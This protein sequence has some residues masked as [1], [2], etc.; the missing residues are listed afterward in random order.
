MTAILA[1]CYPE[2]FVG[3]C[4]HCGVPAGAAQ[5]L[6]SA[7]NVMRHGAPVQGS[8]QGT[9]IPLI[10]FQGC[11]DDLVHPRNATALVRSACTA[12]GITAARDVQ[13]GRV[14]YAAV[15]SA[16]LVEHCE[17]TGAGHAWSGGHVSGSCT[18]PGGLIASAE[19]LRFALSH[20]SEQARH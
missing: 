19:M 8:S 5:D 14:G 2:I 4:V 6:S 7:L 11:S 12:L 13:T 18:A 1:R 10:V 15:G 20:R 17:L 3:V 16:P 9:P